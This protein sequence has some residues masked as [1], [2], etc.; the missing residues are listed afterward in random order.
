MY[1]SANLNWHVCVFEFK[2]G[3]SDLYLQIINN[4]LVI[5]NYV[6]ILN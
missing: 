5:V 1:V 6:I 3:Y 4:G 2:F